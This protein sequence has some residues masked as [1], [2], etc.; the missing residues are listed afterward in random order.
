MGIRGFACY[1]GQGNVSFERCLEHSKS[2]PS[3]CGECGKT[4]T[5]RKGKSKAGKAYKG[6]FCPDCRW[7]GA[8]YPSPAC[9]PR[10]GSR[11]L[12]DDHVALPQRS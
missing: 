8:P 7:R 10:C 5:F 6:S 2:D 11:E 1:W 9:C 3:E 4:M 12:R